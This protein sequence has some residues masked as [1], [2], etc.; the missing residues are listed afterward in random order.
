MIDD[1][2]ENHPGKNG[3]AISSTLTH[4]M[5][6][7]TAPKPEKIRIWGKNQNQNTQP[8]KTSTGISHLGCI[9]EVEM[10]LP[11]ALGT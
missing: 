11:R 5:H 8:N 1:E 6:V 4:E 10:A 3:I 7:K 9:P 2:R